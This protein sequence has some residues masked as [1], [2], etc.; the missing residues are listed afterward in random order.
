MPY[1]CSCGYEAKTSKGLGG[2]IQQR[3]LRGDTTHTSAGG[4]KAPISE[5]LMPPKGNGSTPKTI[6]PTPSVSDS[7]L[8]RLISQ[9]QVIIMTPDI[10][11]G[12]MCAI[13]RGFMG[14]LS[15]WLSLA[16]R[17]FWLGRGIDL[18]REVSGIVPEDLI[19]KESEQEV[20]VANR[21][22]LRVGAGPGLQKG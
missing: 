20:G 1:F 4:T 13:K 17:D 14:N 8:L 11:T 22:G 19:P 15:D 6:A 2:H 5:G 9:S 10:F 18:Y 16:S 3:L 12:Y 21:E 7:A